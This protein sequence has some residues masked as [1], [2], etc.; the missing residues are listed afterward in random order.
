MGLTV[1]RK[2]PKNSTVSR[3]KEVTNSNKISGDYYGK[4]I[5]VSRKLAI[6]LTVSRK[7]HPPIK[8]LIKRRGYVMASEQLLSLKLL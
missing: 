2:P 8:T 7:S 5:T 6:V 1:S 4:I 3:K